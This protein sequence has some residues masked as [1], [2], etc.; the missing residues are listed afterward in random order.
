MVSSVVS[1]TRKPRSIVR[2]RELCKELKVLCKIGRCVAERG[3]DKDALLV[4][5]GI[6]GRFYS[7]EVDVRDI[8]AVDHDRLVVV[9]YNGCLQ[10][11]VPF[12][13]FVGRHV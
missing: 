9:E 6:G 7:V 13:V 3:Q 5:D 4:A 10:M 1:P 8:G 11:G 2:V 12:L